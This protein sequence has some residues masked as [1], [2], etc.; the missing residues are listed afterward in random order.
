MAMAECA[1]CGREFTCVS[2]FDAHQSWTYS[3][4]V[5][6]HLVCVNPWV[7]GMAQNKYGRWYFPVA[8]AEGTPHAS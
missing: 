3:L 1:R 5:G 7:L 2:N 6:A 4:I 8:V